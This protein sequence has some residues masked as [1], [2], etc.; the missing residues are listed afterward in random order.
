MRVLPFLLILLIASCK[1]NKTASEPVAQP[2]TPVETT[3]ESPKTKDLPSLE[4]SIWTSYKDMDLPDLE[5]RIS[6]TGYSLWQ[7][8]Y[9]QLMESMAGSS[10]ELLLPIDD[11]LQLF[12]LE[13]SG[14]MSEALA[15]KFPEIK[16][17]KGYSS[18]KTYSIRM[19]TNEE[20]LFTEIKNGKEIMLLEPFLKGSK[21]FYVLYEKSS[22]PNVPRENF[23][24]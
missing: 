20:G 4:N 9:A 21:T 14:T 22:L 24:K 19:D 12:Q 7:C 16:S 2:A 13:N 15:A 1:S 11:Q 3:A 8:D 17:Y 18:D 10:A 5:R 6:P 23:E